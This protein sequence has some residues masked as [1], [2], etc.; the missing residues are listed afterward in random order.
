MVSDLASGSKTGVAC[1]QCRY[2]EAIV[3]VAGFEGGRARKAEERQ[4]CPRTQAAKRYGT[5]TKGPCFLGPKHTHTYL[6]TL[7]LAIPSCRFTSLLSSFTHVSTCCRHPNTTPAQC[8]HTGT[9]PFQPTYLS[10]TGSARPRGMAP[11]TRVCR[12]C[13]R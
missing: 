2:E 8:A 3:L 12:A 11:L 4:T 5:G 6:E 7:S 10:P 9:P 13:R 1:S